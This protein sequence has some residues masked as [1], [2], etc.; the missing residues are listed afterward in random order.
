LSE[1]I[2]QENKDN[3]ENLYNIYTYKN[4]SV[5]PEEFIGYYYAISSIAYDPITINNYDDKTIYYVDNDNNIIMYKYNN[6]N[7]EEI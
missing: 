3:V 6:G 4:N 7:Y 5:M 2:T 1:Q